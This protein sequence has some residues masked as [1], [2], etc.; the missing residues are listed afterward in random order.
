MATIPLR[1]AGAATVSDG[2]I[3]TIDGLR[4]LAALSVALFHLTRHGDFLPTVPV[5]TWALGYSWAGIQIFFVISG[6][7]LPWSLYRANYGIGRYGRF[8]AKRLVR[9]DPPYLVVVCLIILL[10]YASSLA[11]GFNGKA[12]FAGWAV[13]LGHIGF[14]NAFTGL[15]WLNP[16]FWTL[17]VEFQF[18]LLIG[19]LF[20]LVVSASRSARGCVT[21]AFLAAPFVFRNESFLP[22]QA[23]LFLMG[24][25]VFQLRSGLIQR[26]VCLVVLAAATAEL[27]F[28]SGAAPAIAGLL[29]ALTIGFLQGRDTLL[30]SG[31]LL[32]LG[33]ISYSLYLVHVP[34]GG[35]IVNLAHR[36]PQTPMME[37]A[38]VAAA[39]GI[40]LASAFILYRYVE[41]PARELASRIPWEHA[42]LA[43]RRIKR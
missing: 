22:G 1:S 43:E 16:V 27:W 32:W 9:I 40:S 30:N 35:R 5:L 24:I 18:Y 41:T 26:S 39:L 15:R 25:T 31:P 28:L 38:E 34:I 37:W 10:D 36:F 20:P 6:F 29:T 17:A 33:A 42:I 13:V 21:V 23:C 8:L 11:P 7:I 14:L 3:H 4:G 19:L 2:R 12:N